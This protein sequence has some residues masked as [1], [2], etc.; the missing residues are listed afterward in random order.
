MKPLMRP[1]KLS[2][3]DTSVSTTLYLAQSLASTVR[4]SNDQFKERN[5]FVYFCQ[6]DSYSKSIEVSQT[7]ARQ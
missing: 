6:V 3:R 4:I 5:S 7:P 2:S 1:I